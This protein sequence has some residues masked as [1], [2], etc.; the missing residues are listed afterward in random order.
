MR[1]LTYLGCL[2]VLF[3]LLPEG[4]AAPQ[5][6]SSGKK[7]TAGPSDNERLRQMYEADQNARTGGSIDW[8]VVS[9]EDKERRAAVLSILEE[10]GVRTSN[11]FYHAAMVFQHGETAD[12]IRTAFGL[13][14]LASQMDPDK[15]V[16]RWLSAAAWDRIMMRQGMPQ[17]YGTQFW[18]PTKN[19][20]WEL[21]KIDESAVTD[22]ER[23]RME[24]PPLAEARKKAA[25][26]K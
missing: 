19:S 20:P 13:A 25:A 7:E 10:G 11:D 22:E 18:K 15:K 12:E 21:Y 8:A 1:H 6:P 23:A 5:E 4:A 17:W 3:T 26:M 9:R 2:I 24:V 16:A 14:W